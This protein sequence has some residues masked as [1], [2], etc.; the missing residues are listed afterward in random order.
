MGASR[1]FVIAYGILALAATGRSVYQIMSKFDQAPVAYSLSALSAVVYIAVAVALALSVKSV[2]W[3]RV[4]QVAVWFEAIGVLAVGGLSVVDPALFPADTVWSRF[5]MGY[6]F[7]PLAL[8][9]L[10]LVWLRRSAR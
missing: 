8:P 2:R 5:G 9:L 7:I 4:A 10:S 1:I 6:L 3:R